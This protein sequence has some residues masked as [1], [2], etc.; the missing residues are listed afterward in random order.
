MKQV[1]T[2]KFIEKLGCE[3][4]PITITK[5]LLN[6]RRILSYFSKALDPNFIIRVKYKV[7]H[8]DCEICDEKKDEP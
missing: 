1:S 4:Y 8:S 2:E 3:V 6:K 7:D 5:F